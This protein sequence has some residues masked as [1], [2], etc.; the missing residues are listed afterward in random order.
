MTNRT[1]LALCA[2]AIL[3]SS[4]CAAPAQADLVPPGPGP[5]LV[6]SPPELADSVRLAPRGHITIHRFPTSAGGSQ[7]MMLAGPPLDWYCRDNND[8]AY[9]FFRFTGPTPI[10][11]PNPSV[12]CRPDSNT[13]LCNQVVAGGYHASGSGYMYVTSACDVGPQ[14]TIRIDLPLHDPGVSSSNSGVGS[15]SWTCSIDEA[16]ISS[17]EETDWW[18]FCQVNASP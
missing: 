9:R 12:T 1:P 2:L 5:V 11:G 14:T 16:G 7:W 17:Q 18:A 6:V 10:Y 15:F 8:P 4:L 13:D 3:A